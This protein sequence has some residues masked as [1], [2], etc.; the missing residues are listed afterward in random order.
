MILNTDQKS[1]LSAL[2]S[3]APYV[4]QSSGA[5]VALLNAP[6]SI[7]NPTPQGTVP[8]P[9]VALDLVNACSAG[10]RTALV[11]LLAGSAA[12]LILTQATGPLGA[13][14]DAMAAIG[15]ISTE[16]ATAMKEV[17]AQTFADPSYQ[18]N[19]PGPSPFQSLFPGVAF[20]H[21]DGSITEGGASVDMIEEANS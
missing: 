3:N 11:P 6:T 2:I 12:E 7:A 19:I 17:M 9:F 16:D 14:L 8:K 15:T 1:A 5:I 18:A 21:A 20:T 13:G 10:N 4:G